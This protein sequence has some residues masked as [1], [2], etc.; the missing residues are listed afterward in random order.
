MRGELLARWHRV[1][2][3]ALWATPA[4]LGLGA[5]LVD[6]YSERHRHYHDASHLVAV[7]TALDELAAPHEPSVEVRLAAWFHDAIYS[8][9]AGVDEERSAELAAQRLSE[10]G[11][12]DRS[13]E[14]VRAMVLATAGHIASDADAD[15]GA[16]PDL[17]TALLLDADLSILGAP[18]TTY[19]AYA[20]GVRAEHAHV[21]DERFAT[22]RIAALRTLL[23]R[24]R[25]FHTDAGRQRFDATA[26]ANLRRELAALERS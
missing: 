4:A 23:G 2:D 18:G 24:P 22:G 13:I 12:D 21:S 26:R 7:L 15:D 6:R 1:V 20:R 10:V 3:D 14:Q 8:G 17:D 9:T 25:L 16:G 19:D 5:D 11:A